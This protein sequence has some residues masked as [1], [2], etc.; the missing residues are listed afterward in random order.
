M[1]A[2]NIISLYDLCYQ[3]CVDMFDTDPSDGT[4]WLVDAIDP[5]D[6]MGYLNDAID[7]CDHAD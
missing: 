6:G 3:C 1:Y 5:C 2:T 7:P 4:G